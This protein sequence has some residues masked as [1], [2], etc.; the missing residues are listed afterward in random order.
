MIWVQ[1]VAKISAAYS[2][3]LPS[4]DLLFQYSIKHLH[5]CYSF[6]AEYQFRKYVQL[7]CINY[8][9]F[10]QSF[11]SS[12][13]IWRFHEKSHFRLQLQRYNY[14]LYLIN[15]LNFIWTY[16]RNRLVP[17]DIFFYLGFC[18]LVFL[19]LSIN[20]ALRR[21]R[22]HCYQLRKYTAQIL[23]PLKFY[24]LQASFHWH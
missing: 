18:F 19:H 16:F 4:N 1:F 10:L 6:F 20:T 11:H 24:Q 9:F 7:Y 14:N 15:Q 23:M 21:Q 2:E 17:S 8:I 12:M 13:L 5:I 22:Q 3:V